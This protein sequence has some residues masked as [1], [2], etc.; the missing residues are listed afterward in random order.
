MAC[1][2]VSR[3]YTTY[4]S[5]NAKFKRVRIT[6]AKY[7]LLSL[8]TAGAMLLSARVAGVRV[9]VCWRAALITFYSSSSSSRWT[10]D[11]IIGSSAS[12]PPLN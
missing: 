10:K 1:M 5:A 3:Y 12:L 4:S 11:M 8:V 6:P 7:C 2:N 9:C